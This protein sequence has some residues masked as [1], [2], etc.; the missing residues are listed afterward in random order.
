MAEELAASNLV[1]LDRVDLDH[2]NLNPAGLDEAGL[3]AVDLAEAG[4]GQVDLDAAV[5][6]NQ[7]A[8]VG[9][10]PAGVVEPAG[11]PG[12]RAWAVGLV[13]DCH[14]D[15][16]PAGN[17]AD[18]LVRKADE[19]SRDGYTEDEGDDNFADDSANRRDSPDGWPTR[20]AAGDTRCVA[21]DKDS[22]N[23][24]KPRGCS[25]RDVI[26]SSIPNLPTPKAGC[27][28]ATPRFR[29]PRRN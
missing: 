7:A 18:C 8:Q 26:P 5:W 21:A 16:F 29:F 4:S 23:L 14:R 17:P 6:G 27:P 3:D 12:C 11:D 2:A 20:S 24:P 9:P 22:P 15:E 19:C 13:A 1:D 25:T 28:P 10:V